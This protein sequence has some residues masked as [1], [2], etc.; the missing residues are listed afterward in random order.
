MDQRP[1]A[2]A[3]LVCVLLTSACARP[4]CDPLAPEDFIQRALDDL[5]TH[6]GNARARGAFLAGHP[7]LADAPK[8]A[9]IEQFVKDFPDCCHAE[10]VAA[11]DDWAGKLLA[12]LIAYGNTNVNVSVS[13]TYIGPDGKIHIRWRIL[14]SY[15]FHGCGEMADDSRNFRVFD[16]DERSLPTGEFE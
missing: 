2:I 14:N 8:S 13:K 5:F 3:I 7:E 16:K 10:S 9:L 15:G 4:Q 12:W 11:H 1:L 6:P